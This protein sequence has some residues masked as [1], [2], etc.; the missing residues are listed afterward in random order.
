MQFLTARTLLY[1]RVCFLATITYFCLKDPSLIVSSG[2]V[3]LLGQAM[4]LPTVMVD[5]SN[6]IWGLLALAFGS[7]T[8]ADLVPLFADNIEYFESVVP[9]RL[10]VYF[11]LGAYSFAGNS[12]FL[13]NNL[14]FVFAFFEIWFNFLIFNNL[15]DERYKRVKKLLEE[16]EARGE[17]DLK[18]LDQAGINQLMTELLQQ[19]R[20][21]K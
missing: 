15:R 16:S 18:G 8:I 9:A 1:F 19:S 6:P 12:E 14:V 17:I 5:T 4:E 7:L 2:F 13:C 11:I 3:I 10:T 20:F 21:N